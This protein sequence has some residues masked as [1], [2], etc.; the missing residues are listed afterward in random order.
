MLPMAASLS[1]GNVLAG[2]LQ[3][4][5]SAARMM[6]MGLA[7]ATVAG[8][9]MAALLEVHAAWAFVIAAMAVFGLGTAL[10]VPPMIAAILE[11]VPAESAGVASGLL[12]ALRQA[13]SLLGVAFAG[14]AT[15]LATHLT[16]A[17]TVVGVLAGV[18][19]AGAACLAASA[20]VNR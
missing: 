17:L 18:T 4:R 8:P 3:G 7:A 2:K 20:T 15:M 5:L 6:T 9:A 12:N 14:A 16:T 10:S 19:Y 11:Q 1:L 13:G